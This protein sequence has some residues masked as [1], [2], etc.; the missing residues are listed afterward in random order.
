MQKATRS[1][2]TQT[3][4]T[5]RRTP[6]ANCALLFTMTR[7]ASRTR[8][9]FTNCNLFAVIEIEPCH[10]SASLYRDGCRLRRCGQGSGNR[11][12]VRIRSHR[13]HCRKSR[14]EFCGRLPA[15]LLSLSKRKSLRVKDRSGSEANAFTL[16]YFFCVSF[17]LVFESLK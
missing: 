2:S 1:P 9:I 11:Q 17:I 6:Q 12:I 10:F 4:N 7:A 8:Y 5:V 3:C 16:I 14:Q 15:H 13:R